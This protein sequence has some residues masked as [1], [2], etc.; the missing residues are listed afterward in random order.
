MRDFVRNLFGRVCTGPHAEGMTHLDQ[1]VGIPGAS[2]S[3][4]LG[5]ASLP[6]QRNKHFPQEDWGW[7]GLYPVPGVGNKKTRNQGTAELQ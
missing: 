1:G 6:C 3:E 2:V 5:L 4:P 7:T